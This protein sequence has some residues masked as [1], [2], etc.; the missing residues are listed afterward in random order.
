MKKLSF[1]SILLCAGFTLAYGQTQTADEEQ[2]V[3]YTD[4]SNVG[5]TFE[6]K[7]DYD[8]IIT[9]IMPDIFEKKLSE[10]GIAIDSEDVVLNRG[11]RILGYLPNSYN[12]GYVIDKGQD[13]VYWLEAAI[14]RTH[15]QYA[16]FY[17]EIPK[18]GNFEEM[19]L[20]CF[21]PLAVQV[22]EHFLEEKSYLTQDEESR[23]SSTMKHELRGNENL[24]NY[25]F[26][27]GKFNL[28]YK[29]ESILPF[30]GMFEGKMAGSKYFVGTLNEEDQLSWSLESRLSTIC[31]IHENATLHDAKFKERLHD[32]S[33]QAWK[34]IRN[35]IVYIKHTSAE[36][37]L[38][39][40]YMRTESVPNLNLE[41]ATSFDVYFVDYRPESS[42]TLFYFDHTKHDTFAKVR[43][44]QGGANYYMNYGPN[45]WN[46]GDVTNVVISV[47]ED[48][49][50]FTQKTFVRSPDAPYPRYF[51]DY[52]FKV[53]KDSTM[54]AIVLEI[55]NYKL[56]E[57]HNPD[58]WKGRDLRKS[59]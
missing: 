28:D 23:V 14:N 51:T 3:P 7:I 11:A 43:V 13:K 30:C 42:G 48:E 27:I 57:D 52:I 36:K 17:E 33:L 18:G 16:D 34:N 4:N 10:S 44:P 24:N 19:D 8:H 32:G 53:P 6:G 38:E 20:D 5:F 59:N 56:D 39:R 55:E 25:Q 40:N 35:E 49:P 9:R 2:L 26:K 41:Y 31:A 29:N 21:Y 37:L 12:C 50:E 15:I 1:F 45:E 22:A 47:G 58:E 54:M 46:K